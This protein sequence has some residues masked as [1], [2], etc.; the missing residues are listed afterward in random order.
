MTRAGTPRRRLSRLRNQLRDII[1][2][3]EGEAAHLP[4]AAGDLG[5]AI[6]RT[7][8]AAE[9]IAFALSKKLEGEP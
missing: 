9:C 2:E 6:S 3:L 1:T 7:A 4:V 5:R 8:S